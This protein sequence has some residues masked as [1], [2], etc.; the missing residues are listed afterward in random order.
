MIMG[1]AEDFFA[2]EDA[3]DE[4]KKRRVMVKLPQRVVDQALKLAEERNAKEKRYGA[5]TYGGKLGGVQAHILGILG[6]AAVAYQTGQDVDRRI[7]DTHGDDG[8][9]LIVPGMG[10]V[11]IKTTTYVDDP[12][13]RVEMEH[14]RDDIDAY[15][16]CAINSKHEVVIVGWATKDDV[17]KGE[18]KQFVPGGPMNY[19]LREEVLKPWRL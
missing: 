13:M 3:K 6:E 1:I 17:K 12:Y 4:L 5:M 16:L 10:K 2:R 11:G 18:K 15:I 8:I 19:V 14:F 7:F 9:D